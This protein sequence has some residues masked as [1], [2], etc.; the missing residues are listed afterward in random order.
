MPSFYKHLG[1]VLCSKESTKEAQIPIFRV[2]ASDS[3]QQAAGKNLGRGCITSPTWAEA[4]PARDKTKE[5]R[6]QSQGK[7]ASTRE[8]RN[9]EEVDLQRSKRDMEEGKD[10]GHHELAPALELQRWSGVHSFSPQTQT[11]LCAVL[12]KAFVP[13]QLCGNEGTI[14][15]PSNK[16]TLSTCRV[17]TG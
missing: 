17:L 10:L 2:L 6:T 8:H 9:P 1:L 14:P 4:M 7:T 15:C 13:Q 12:D 5:S 16:Y 11:H 3:R